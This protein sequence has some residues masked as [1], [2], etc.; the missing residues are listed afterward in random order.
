MN[1]QIFQPKS[2]IAHLV[3]FFW[4]LEGKGPYTHYTLPSS[5]PELIFHIKGRFTELAGGKKQPSFTAG[6]HAQS[7]QTR[8]FHIAGEFGI[9]GVFLYP[10]AV[11]ILFGLPSDEATGHLLDLDLIASGPGKALEEAVSGACG[12]EQRIRLLEDF[13]ENRA[14][15]ALNLPLF[16]CIQEIIKK[17]G[18]VRITDLPNTACLSMRQFQRQFTRHAG[19]RPK[20]FSRLVRFEAVTESYGKTSAPLSEIAQNCGYYDQSHFAGEFR[21]LSGISP[22]DYFSGQSGLTA[23]KDS[24]V[25]DPR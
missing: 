5:C 6:L 19:L 21:E 11:P 18:L 9:F 3:R 7:M 12:T 10:H 1:Y 14:H 8:R 17:R 23:W 25:A 16:Q 13:V 2:S 22:K 24:H 4:I 20:L 15:G